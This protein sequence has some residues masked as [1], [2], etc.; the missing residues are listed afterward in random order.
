MDLAFHDAR[1]A[2]VDPAGLVLGVFLPSAP[3]GIVPLTPLSLPALPPRALFSRQAFEPACQGRGPRLSVKM[4]RFLQP[5][6]PSI[7]GGHSHACAS[8]CRFRVRSRDVSATARP[9]A[10]FHPRLLGAALASPGLPRARPPSPPIATPRDFHAERRQ[11]LLW[12]K[13]AAHRLL[14]STS[15]ARTH[16]RASDSRF[17]KAPSLCGTSKL[18]FVFAALFTEPRLSPLEERS[19]KATSRDSPSDTS[20]RRCK[21]AAEHDPGNSRPTETPLAGGASIRS[22]LAAMTVGR[23]RWT[24]RAELP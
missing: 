5:K 23:K 14:Q 9:S 22:P 18:P 24:A 15:D 8:R 2:S 20:L 6:V 3:D 21:F 12:V 16:P 11:V 1:S 13:T 17:F 10:P 7:A 19:R 4:R